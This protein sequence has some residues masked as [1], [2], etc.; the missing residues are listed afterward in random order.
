MAFVLKEMFDNED[1][2]R[3]IYS[4]GYPEYRSHMDNI[5]FQ[6]N[7][8]HQHIT[9]QLFGEW[10]DS[11]TSES[12]GVYCRENYERPKILELY[13]KYMKCY[14]CTRH[15]YYKPDILK[16][17]YNKKKEICYYQSDETGCECECRHMTRHLYTSYWLDE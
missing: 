10:N 6:I 11:M 16:K 7:T 4:F 3:Y 1:I 8:T 9:Y 13:K 17:K 5:C 12:L 2:I 15:S 14:C